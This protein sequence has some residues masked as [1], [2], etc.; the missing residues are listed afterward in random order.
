MV[1]GASIFRIPCHRQVLES[2]TAPSHCNSVLNG[3]G[4]RKPHYQIR[5]RLSQLH[6]V[7][8]LGLLNYGGPSNAQLG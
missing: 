2:Y 1:E 7:L 6:H 8:H 3:L 4:S 5:L